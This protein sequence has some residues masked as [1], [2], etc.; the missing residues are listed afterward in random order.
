MERGVR[1]VRRTVKIF[2]LILLTAL[3]LTGC[4][5][6]TVDQLYC[7]PKRSQADNDLQTVIDE[8][9]EGLFYSAP[10]YGENRQ[11]VQMADLDGDGVEEYLLFARDNSEKPLKILIEIPIIP[12]KILSSTKKKIQLFPAIILD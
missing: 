6:R 11:P 7:L 1:K 8:A 2:L 5:L 12:P 9:M 3:M 10:L 4:G